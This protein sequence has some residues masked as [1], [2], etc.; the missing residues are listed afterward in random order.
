MK[1]SLLLIV[2]ASLAVASAGP[3]EFESR[4]SGVQGFDISGW[5]SNVN[6]AGAY[7]SG[8]RF[9]MIKASEGTT[10]K[11]RQFSN[12]YIGATKAGFIRGGYHFALPDVSSATAQV[13]HFLA[14]GGGWSRDGITLP[15]M[16]DI[17]SNPYGAQCYGLDAGRMVAWIREFV[18][19]Y[20]RATGRY[21]LIYTSPSW[22]QTCTGNSNAFIDKCPLVL[23]RWASSPGTPPGGWPFHSF[24]QYADSYQFGGDAQV[25]NGDEAGLKRMALG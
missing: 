19:A 14:S 4:A 9:V 20:K 3:K 18:D 13:N 24:W 1:L 21:P 16:L 15:G 17:E 12:H 5:Q 7:N 6:F 22:W 10:F 8:A 25:F 2:A 11:D 23:A